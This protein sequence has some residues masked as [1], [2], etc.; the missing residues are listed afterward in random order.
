[1]QADKIND[2][3]GQ[4]IA[5]EA[6]TVHKYQG[7]EKD[8]II[9]TTVVNELNS[10]VDDANL[11]NVAISRA[12]KKIIVVSSKN[13]SK[14][15]GT[16]IGDFI[17]YIE[18]NARS[19]EIVNSNI[20]SVFDILYSKYSEKLLAEIKKIKKVSE[21]KSENLMNMVIERVLSIR[22]ITH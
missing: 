21:N 17:R 20:V 18:Y 16:N 5:V 22:S 14:Q 6:D 2:M 12:I 13:I 11:V 3:K 19:E 7:R 10:F 4:N 8:T 9:M 15:H 1:M